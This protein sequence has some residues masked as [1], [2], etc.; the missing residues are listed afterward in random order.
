M[1]MQ[2][3]RQMPLLACYQ[4]DGW[5]SAVTTRHTVICDGRV[6]RNARL[7]HEFLLQVGY[8]KIL[9]IHG[10]VLPFCLLG[11]PIALRQESGR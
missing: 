7:R 10:K 3:H 8:F 9:D 11:G 6:F 1:A 2:E 4:S 5:S